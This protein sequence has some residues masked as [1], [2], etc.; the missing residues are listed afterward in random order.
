MIV[1][2]F[3]APATL[4]ELKWGR[5]VLYI[6]GMLEYQRATLKKDGCTQRYGKIKRLSSTHW[7][8]YILRLSTWKGKAQE[9]GEI[10]YVT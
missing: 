2:G 10:V 5:N 9:K 3:A 7:C 4:H 8:S 6:V 1:V